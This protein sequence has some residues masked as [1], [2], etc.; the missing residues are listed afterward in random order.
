M[1]FALA[2]Q[3]FGRMSTDTL[4]H[5]FVWLSQDVLM[6]S[7]LANVVRAQAEVSARLAV[8]T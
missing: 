3:S 2:G 5:P 8:L 1:L 4:A 6:I 7:Y